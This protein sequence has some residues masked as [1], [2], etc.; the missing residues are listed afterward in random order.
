[1]K[2]VI[3]SIALLSGIAFTTQAQTEKGKFIIGGNVSYSTLK[4]DA[5]GAKASHEFSIV[6]NVGYF[7]SDNIAVGT[8]IGY[9]SSKA[10]HASLTG[11]QEAFVIAPFGR[12]YTPI[13]NNFKFFGNLSV[14]MAFGTTKAIDGD[15]KVGDKNGNS[16]S[17]G[18]ALSPGFAYYPSSK[19]G[20]EFAFNGISYIN[21]S[22]EDANGNKLKGEGGDGFSIGTDF[23]APKIGIQFH[24]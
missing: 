1:M 21:Q 9:L 24:F 19:I 20:I 13:A 16:T 10:S 12:Y 2:K 6:P 14:P 15:L 5:D 4:S 17:I 8:G 18:V 11:K 7:V 3:L 22:F 23:F